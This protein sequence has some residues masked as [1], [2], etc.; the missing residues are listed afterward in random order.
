MSSS[1]CL[2]LREILFILQVLL[3][4]FDGGYEMFRKG[5]GTFQGDV[6]WLQMCIS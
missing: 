3:R 2:M 5:K 6:G 4:E 1:D